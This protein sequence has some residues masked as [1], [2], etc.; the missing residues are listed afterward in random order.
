[1][2]RIHF[3]RSFFCNQITGSFVV[4]GVATLINMKKIFSLVL[5]SIAIG[6][7]F[8]QAAE[9]SLKVAGELKCKSCILK[10]TDKCALVL[11]TVEKGQKVRYEVP[12]NDTVRNLHSKPCE[13][14]QKVKGSG[15]VVQVDG[16]NQLTF[17]QIEFAR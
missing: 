13:A 14:V 1:V 8:V 4:Q 3:R 10:E 5:A 15:V 12:L 16:K 17:S 11:E 9:S 7:V 6:A 2:R